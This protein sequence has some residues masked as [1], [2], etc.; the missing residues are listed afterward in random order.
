[1]NKRIDYLEQY[2]NPKWQKLRLK[3]LERDKWCCQ[4][5]YDDESQLQVHHRRY[6][7]GRKIWEYDKCDLVTLCNECH[8]EEKIFM[9]EGM[10]KFITILKR[11]LFSIHINDLHCSLGWLFH[12]NLHHADIFI[13]ALSWVIENKLEENIIIP[14]HEHCR[15]NAEKTRSKDG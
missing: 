1:M 3:I 11:N 6:I 14:Y 13:S 9:K 15:I 8:A 2:K 10:E 7:Y 5:C 12:E 4:R